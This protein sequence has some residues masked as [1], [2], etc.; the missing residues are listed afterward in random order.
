MTA[1]EQHLAAYAALYGQSVAQMANALPDMGDG[2]AAQ[3]KALQRDPSIQECERLAANLDG[4]R[5]AVLRLREQLLR[6]GQ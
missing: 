3:C 6:D 1:T 4:A 2:L 5:R